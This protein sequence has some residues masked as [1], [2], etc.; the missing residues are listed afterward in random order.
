MESIFF[1]LKS[2]GRIL[3]NRHS[4]GTC[5]PW[6]ECEL[7]HPHLLEP[8]AFLSKIPLTP[9]T[10]HLSLIP[11]LFATGYCQSQGMCSM[12]NTV[13]LRNQLLQSWNLICVQSDTNIKRPL[14]FAVA[15]AVYA[16]ESTSEALRGLDWI[17]SRKCE[18]SIALF[19]RTGCK[20]IAVRLEH[21]PL[22]R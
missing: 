6:C 2:L 16:S 5:V 10:E 1:K 20:R 21:K 13:W 19:R 22:L 17:V 8:P 9:N 7:I 15:S 4:N 11:A 12:P 3:Y 14:S 18:L